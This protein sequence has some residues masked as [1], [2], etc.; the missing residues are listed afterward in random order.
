MHRSGPVGRY[1]TAAGTGAL[2]V[3]LLVGICGS[4]AFTSWAGTQTDPDSAAAFYVRLLA[5]PAWRLDA[6][7]QA[8]GL[9]AADVRAVLL[10]ILAVGL[11]YLLPAAQ[12]ARVPGS[13]SQFFSGWAAYVL[14]GGLAAV[15]AALLGPNPSMLGALQDAST[16]AGY[17]F[18]TG[19]IIG[20]ASLGGRA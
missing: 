16:G 20:T 5:W 3:L 6:D 2:A 10:V 8:G 18:L 7:G 14:A 11:L 12:V 17:G 9:F 19:W 4:P 1:G 13:V 15:L